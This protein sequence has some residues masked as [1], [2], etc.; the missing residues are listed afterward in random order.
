M[1]EL[2]T[3]TNQ[4]NGKQYVGKTNRSAAIRY[5]EHTKDFVLNNNGNRPLYRAMNKYGVESFNMKVIQSEL[6]PQE[7]E[8]LEIDLIHKLGTFNNGYN[9]TVGGDGKTYRLISDEDIAFIVDL[10]AKDK[11]TIYEIARILNADEETIS[12]RLKDAGITIN[13]SGHNFFNLPIIM[14][15]K[16]GNEMLFKTGDDLVEY[17]HSNNLSVAKKTR[18]A[19]GVQRVVSGKRKSY[20]QHTYKNVD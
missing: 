5:K 4:V 18:I 11:K 16:Q 20:L 13:W 17:V 10:Y 7:A 12:T 3:I 1:A 15:D 9:A 19:E 14:I 2:Y 6:S 8:E